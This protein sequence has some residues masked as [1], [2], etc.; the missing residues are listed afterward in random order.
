[1]LYDFGCLAH[2][3]TLDTLMAALTGAVAVFAV[4]AGLA[5]L[6]SLLNRSLHFQAYDIFSGWGFAAGVLTLTAVLFTHALPFVT[7]GLFAAMIIAAIPALKRRYFV[8][9]FWL[10]AL[11]PGLFVLTALNIAGI[12]KWDDFSHWVPNALY[13]FQNNDVPGAGLP[14]AYSVWPGYPYALPFLTYMASWLADGFL[15]QG[16]AMNNFM[17]LMAFA[18]LLT[19]TT[20]DLS[21]KRP[22]TL[23][24]IGMMGLA[25][26]V[27]TLANP[28]F[29]ASF[30]MTNQGDTSTM[31]LVGSLGILFWH[32][33]TLLTKNKK[34][35]RAAIKTLVVPIALAAIALILV[36]QVNIALLGILT[37]A[38]L[39]LAWKNKVLKPAL[40]W[41]PAMILPAL[42]MRFVWQYYVNAE[43]AGNGFGIRPLH[44]WRFD[45]LAP[46]LQSM[47]LEMVEKNGLFIPMWI[48]AGFGVISLFRPP[49][50][51]R[52]ILL[53]TAI[54]FIGY[55]SF[56]LM[57]YLGATFTESEIRRAG[58]LYRYTSHVGLLEIAA[59]WVAAPALWAWT[60]KKLALR[61]FKYF[62]V[63]R[64]PEARLFYVFFLVI[65]LPL[66]FWIRADWLVPQPS[67][68]A[69]SARALGHKIAE[70]L[71]DDAN[72]VVL[73]PE[74]NGLL[75]F[76]VKLELSL[77]NVRSGKHMSLAWWLEISG[78]D[79]LPQQLHELNT[80]PS[81]TAVLLPPAKQTPISIGGHANG[82]E[83]VFLVRED[84]KWKRIPL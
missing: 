33:I 77:E 9:P 23:H 10:F 25:L 41:L 55:L 81:L 4:S 22:L 13:L 6:G 60:R 31:V 47:A 82:D 40:L 35:K 17:L 11:F 62:S 76:M 75:P 29:N 24:G 14:P 19:F 27:T 79:Q 70:I 80:N 46:L 30:T 12:A 18:A 5:A 51:L 38:F 8:S 44:E 36:K 52:N 3:L 53:L 1:M 42:I 61:S 69:C 64:R 83:M 26:L 73:D 71:P 59:L 72:L 84:N 21:D 32:A 28:S 56:L 74:G 57:T 2:P 50:P 20:R 16:G 54:G 66:A 45:L 37:F 58:Y 78:A 39:V 68:E 49:T 43:L 15:M 67:T 65:L 48:I 7:F 34:N 63:R